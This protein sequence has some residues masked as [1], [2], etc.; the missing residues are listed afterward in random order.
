VGKMKLTPVNLLH[1]IHEALVGRSIFFFK[2]KMDERKKQLTVLLSTLSGVL[3]S[4]LLLLQFHGILL[5]KVIQQQRHLQHL[6][7]EAI[8][9]RNLALSRYHRIRK[10]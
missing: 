9:S 1:D 3:T 2:H 10:R 8:L 4:T 7:N 5:M 6:R